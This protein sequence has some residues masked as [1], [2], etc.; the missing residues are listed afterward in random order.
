[1]IDRRSKAAK[2]SRQV[3]KLKEFVINDKLTKIIVE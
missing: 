1:M 3:C 2:G